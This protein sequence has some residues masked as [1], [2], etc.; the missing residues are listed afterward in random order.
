M[1]IRGL[2]YSIPEEILKQ[3]N[4]AHFALINGVKPQD[5]SMPVT[6]EEIVAALGDIDYQTIKA[7][8]E[9]YKRILK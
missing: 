6:S 2:I 1:Q 3:V 5:G 9:F 4:G 7:Q 8:I